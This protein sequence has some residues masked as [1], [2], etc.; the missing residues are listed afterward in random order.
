MVSRPVMVLMG[1]DSWT[2]EALHRA[3]G[4]A[5]TNGAEVALVKM[6]PVQHVGW[7]GTEFGYQNLN[8]EDRDALYDYLT[9]PEDYGVRFSVQLFQYVTL[10]EAISDAAEYLDAESV[11]ATLP[12]GQIPL[13]R[14][15]SLARLRRRLARHNRTLIISEELSRTPSDSRRHL[16]NLNLA[17]GGN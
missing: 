1:E 11:F 15:W 6:I 10:P 13:W 16:E 4:L 7:L 17:P 3:C 8:W 14:A 5:R 2:V 9:I 12:A